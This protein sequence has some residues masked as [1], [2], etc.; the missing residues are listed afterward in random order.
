M[1]SAAWYARDTLMQAL[2]ASASASDNGTMSP[3]VD[4]TLGFFIP[5]PTAIA[6]S[7]IKA[8]VN[9]ERSSKL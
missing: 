3:S 4:E 7:L 5:P 1:A 2:S 6:H 9:K 8:W